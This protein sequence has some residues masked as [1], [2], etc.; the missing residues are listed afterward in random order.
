MAASA[1]IHL[2]VTQETKLRLRALAQREGRTESA[3]LKELLGVML[4]SVGDEVLSETRRDEGGI[5]QARLTVRLQASDHVLLRDRAEARAMPAATYVSVLVRA[6][7]RSLTPW[8]KD[9]L[10]A[11]KRSIAELAAIGRNINQIVKVANE[12]G[13]FPGSVREEFRAMLKICE[14]LRENTKGLLK[15]NLRSWSVGHSEAGA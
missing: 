5:R 13:G 12:G 15:A 1:F 11:L 10:L 14:A 4:R 2:R 7:L 9:E 6:H 3:L 8:P